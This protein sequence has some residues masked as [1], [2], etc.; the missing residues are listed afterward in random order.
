MKK[1]LL[2]QTAFIGDVILS[3]PLIANLH[4]QFPNIQIDY[5][6][7]KGNEELLS[8]HPTV[9]KVFIFDK[10]NKWV[11]LRENIRLIRQEK[12]D[13][14]V[15]LHRYASSGLICALS[16]AKQKIGFKKNPFSFL[17]SKSYKHAIGNGEHEVDR[18]LCL[19]ASFCDITIRKPSLYPS[20]DDYSFVSKFQGTAYSC[21]A[22]AS[23]WFTKQA[24]IATWLKLIEKL[25]DSDHA[26]FLMGGPNDKA[27][28][29][30]IISESTK[31][32]RSLAGEL[33]IMQSV[34]FMKNAKRNFVND[35]GPLHFASAVNAPVTAFF[36][37]TI[38]AFGFGPLS[39]DS[40]IIEVAGLPC[41]PCGL[42]GHKTCPEGHFKCGELALED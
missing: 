28:C 29:D 1:I 2:I 21:L 18:N 19:I 42:H 32:V 16:G 14:I 17:Y 34:A 9:N 12:Y 27:L 25:S 40:K 22:P 15:N 4:K 5:L 7:K 13:T 30:Q 24:P 26:I 39:E 20:S 23:I 11:S 41:R 33:S 6:V 3:T 37:S 38:P 31:E 8:G 35:S 36:C 10:G